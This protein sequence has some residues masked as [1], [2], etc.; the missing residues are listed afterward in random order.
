M[1]HLLGVCQAHQ[2]GRSA[3][4]IEVSASPRKQKTGSPPSPAARGTASGHLHRSR[5]PP[6]YRALSAGAEMKVIG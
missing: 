1:N 6:R 4:H 3:G 2:R 5:W